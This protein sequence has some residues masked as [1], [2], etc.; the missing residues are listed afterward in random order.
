MQN[1]KLH[2]LHSSPNTTKIDQVKMVGHVAG[3]GEIRN[4]YNVL[5]E[6]PGVM[7]PL[8]KLRHRWEDNIKIYLREIQWE[9]LNW[10]HFTQTEN[11]WQAFANIGV[12]LHLL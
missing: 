5:V 12:N 2:M 1:G 4:T 9:G 6:K 11:Q 3:T 8:G 10:T 7:K